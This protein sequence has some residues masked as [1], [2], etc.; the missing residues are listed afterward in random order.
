MGQML[1]AMA[2]CKVVSHNKL[3]H[4]FISYA[5][6][7]FSE[8][9]GQ[10][11]KVSFRSFGEVSVATCQLASPYIEFVPMISEI[12]YNKDQVSLYSCRRTKAAPLASIN[13]QELIPKIKILL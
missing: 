4:R 7:W 3:Q 8:C 10:D 9:C 2:M 12:R 11:N 13:K 5:D 1:A 6:L